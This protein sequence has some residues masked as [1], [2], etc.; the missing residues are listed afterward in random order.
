MFDRR[1]GEVRARS[2]D[3]KG[4]NTSEE[5]REGR[6]GLEVGGLA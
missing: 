6:L 5:L 1:T 3:N 2:V 4:E